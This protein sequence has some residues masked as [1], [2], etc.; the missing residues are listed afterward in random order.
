[1]SG[2]AAAPRKR[3]KRKH[4]ARTLNDALAKHAWNSA[5]QPAWLNERTYAEKI[6][7]RLID[8]TVS[9]L[10]SALGASSRRFSL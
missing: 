9:A 5:D 6:Q 10:S 2:R 1:M 3:R 8:S 7:P 4:A